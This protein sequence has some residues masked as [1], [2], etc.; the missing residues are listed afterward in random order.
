MAI[1]WYVGK[2][3]RGKVA[4]AQA[5]LKLRGLEVSNPRI[6]VPR[7]SHSR[8]EDLFP[9][10]LFC[11]LDPSC[12]QHWPDVL[13]TPC[14]RYFLPQNAPP[15]PLNGQAMEEIWNGVEEWNNGGFVQVYQP[16]DHLQ[17]KSG[18]LEGLNAVFQTYLPPKERCEALIN[19]F[20]R[21]L[22][23]TI[24]LSDLELAPTSETELSWIKAYQRISTPITS[25]R[26]RQEP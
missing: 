8:W 16:G 14:F 12:T 19:W 3:K 20:G 2:V 6:L 1:G 18:A 17:I 7:R 21:K 26:G 13:W 25:T 24:D 5:L 23:I 10:Y 4:Q 9:G 22:L 11:H 15:V